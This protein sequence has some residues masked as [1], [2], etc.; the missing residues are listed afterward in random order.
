M[1]LSTNFW[2][3]G[4]S[5]S[6]LDNLTSI[7]KHIH[8]ALT[9]HLWNVCFPKYYMMMPVMMRMMTRI[10]ITVVIIQITLLRV[11][12][13][14][15]DTTFYCFLF[16]LPSFNRPFDTHFA[17]YFASSFTLLCRMMLPSLYRSSSKCTARLLFVLPGPNSSQCYSSFPWVQCQWNW[18]MNTELRN[19]VEKQC[20]YLYNVFL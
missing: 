15:F 11:S 16:F 6:S 9:Y 18:Y 12:Y 20:S 19:S 14:F 13:F 8:A 2:C 10:M 5:Y 1:D 7:C 17:I 3:V 4:F